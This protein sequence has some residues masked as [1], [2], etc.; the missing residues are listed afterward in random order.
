MKYI[1]KFNKFF[2]NAAPAPAKP[3]PDRPTTVP[4]MPEKPQKPQKPIKPIVRPS[5]DPE[6]KAEVTE[7]DVAERFIK[8]LNKKGE[9]VKNYL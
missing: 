5:V 9:S 2:E 4:R 8:E 6:P 1:K 7:M 3:M